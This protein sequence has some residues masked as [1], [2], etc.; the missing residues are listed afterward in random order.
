MKYLIATIMVL[1]TTNCYADNLIQFETPS[2]NIMCS[3]DNN[4]ATCEIFE[5]EKTYSGVIPEWCE[6]DYGNT[7]NVTTENAERMCISDTYYGSKFSTVEYGSKIYTKN[8]FCE[9]T[10]KGVMCKNLKG[11]GFH[12]SRT[13]QKLF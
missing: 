5:V 8:I 4:S 12:I 13:I 1:I 2:K 3:I 7:F 6:Y 10:L 9:V 11:S